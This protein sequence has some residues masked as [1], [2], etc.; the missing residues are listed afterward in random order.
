M[1]VYIN[2]VSQMH[3]IEPSQ[4]LAE[5]E[6][7]LRTTP[8]TNVLHQLDPETLAWLGRAASIIKRWSPSKSIVFDS[9]IRQLHAGRAFNPT[10][11]VAGILTSLHE[12]R[13][14]LRLLTVGPLAVAVKQGAVFDYFDEIRKV[15]ASAHTEL[16]FVDPYVDA[17]SHTLG[18]GLC[19]CRNDLPVGPG[20]FRNAA[21]HS[22]GQEVR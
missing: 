14:D 6:D 12:A 11:A 1:A 16:F 2:W 3:Q 9:E 10:S 20:R 21:R 7:L 22:Q 4:L 5:V 13:H 17:E 18:P 19:C 15:I 8:A